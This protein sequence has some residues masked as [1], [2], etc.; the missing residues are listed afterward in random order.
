MKSRFVIITCIVNLLL[1]FCASGT[2]GYYQ[3]QDDGSYV[4]GIIAGRSDTIPI[5]PA[6]AHITGYNVLVTVTRR[7]ANTSTDMEMEIRK[8]CYQDPVIHAE[9]STRG[10]PEDGP[11][12]VSFL[13]EEFCSYNIIITNHSG[14]LNGVLTISSSPPIETQDTGEDQDTG[15][16]GGRV[17]TLPLMQRIYLPNRQITWHYL[18]SILEY[19][20]IAS[21]ATVETGREGLPGYDPR[22]MIDG[23]PATVWKSGYRTNWI[24]LTWPTPVTICKV[25]L[26]GLDDYVCDIEGATLEFSEGE[27]ILDI[28]VP[29]YRSERNNSTAINFPNRTVNWV[30]LTITFDQTHGPYVGLGEFEVYRAE[31]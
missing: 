14:I 25:F 20:N 29:H 27:P 2:F 10:N 30:Q 19:E 12:S 31:E 24:R 1:F 16:P 9:A 15:I 22:A 17:I 5:S 26:Y 21:S 7:E 4:L 28:D 8:T 13:G 6:D 11:V 18:Y 3:R 23:N